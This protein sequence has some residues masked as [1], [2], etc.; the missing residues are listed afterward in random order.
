MVDPMSKKKKSPSTQ[1]RNAR[2]KEEFIFKKRQTPS[3]VAATEESAAASMFPCDQCDYTNASEKGLRQHQRMKHGKPQLNA[4]L[5]SSSPSTPESL[6]QP[7]SYSDALALS[8]IQDSSRVIPCNNCDEDMSPNH[9]CPTHTCGG[10]DEVFNSEEELT[11][12]EG[13]VHPNM[14]HICFKF[15]V[16]SGSFGTHF[17][18]E[19]MNY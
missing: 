5:Q 2:R 9:I 7:T 19:H 15:F 13:T 17:R 18:Q 3:T 8:P 6:R 16:D 10:C 14:C 4:Q 12:H 11:N 1:R